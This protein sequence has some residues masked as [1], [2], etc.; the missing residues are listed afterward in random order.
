MYIITFNLLV[1]SKKN[2]KREVVVKSRVYFHNNNQL[3]SPKNKS[4]S[5]YK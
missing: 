2:M 4:M 3:I 5:T 1:H